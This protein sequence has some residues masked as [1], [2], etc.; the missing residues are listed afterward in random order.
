VMM[1]GWAGQG[2][3][4]DGGGGGM[5]KVGRV[6]DVLYSNT[7]LQRSYD[8]SSAPRPLKIDFDGPS[9]ACRLLS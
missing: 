2:S 5:P 9:S 1:M 7:Y 3:R 6:M 4:V 8:D